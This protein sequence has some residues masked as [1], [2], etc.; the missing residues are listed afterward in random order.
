M[1]W[2]FLSSAELPFFLY[3]FGLM[4]HMP[5]LQQY[6]YLR[7][8]IQD[9]FPYHFSAHQTSCGDTLNKTLKALQE[10]VQEQSA[11]FQIAL[12]LCNTLP[13]LFVCLIYGSWSDRV[14]RKPLIVLGMCGALL[15][16]ICVFFTILLDLPLSFM[17]FGSFLNGIGGYITGLLLAVMAYIADTTGEED[18]A[19]R[20]GVL[21][22]VVFLGSMVS[23]FMSGHLIRA[24]GFKYSYIVVVSCLFAAC[25]C[26]C[27]LMKESLEGKK[28][29]LLKSMFNKESLRYPLHVWHVLTKPRPYKWKIGVMFPAT[30]FANMLSMGISS[31]ITL[32]VLNSPFCLPSI[33]VGYFTGTRFMVLGVGAALGIKL[34]RIWFP[35]YIISLF[36]ILSYAAFYTTLSF[37]RTEAVLY[38]GE[39]IRTKHLG[40]H[41]ELLVWGDKQF[42]RYTDSLCSDFALY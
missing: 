23:Q 33:Q 19:L 40:E 39:L 20:L 27:F 4:L 22:A 7:F 35:Q 11:H 16:T 30:L 32:Y 37:A 8:S 14:G 12:S 6:A 42:F 1:L 34:L 2:R 18:R 15:D 21:E 38:V 13:S 24:C 10:K 5:I 29:S 3:V 17:L 41:I 26:S 28:P 9:N 25:F 36:G 31:V